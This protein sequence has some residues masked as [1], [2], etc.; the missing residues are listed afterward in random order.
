MEYS[1]VSKYLEELDELVHEHPSLPILASIHKV[2]LAQPASTQILAYNNNSCNFT[3]PCL[4]LL[5]YAKKHP[6]MASAEFYHVILCVGTREDE[7]FKSWVVRE[8][9]KLVRDPN[10]NRESVQTFRI[11]IESEQTLQKFIQKLKQQLSKES[12]QKLHDMILL[13]LGHRV[14]EEHV[15]KKR[16]INVEIALYLA[17]LIAFAQ[18]RLVA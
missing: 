3:V 13:E 16:K 12:M 1:S 14:V 7:D 10:L 5:R 17:L 11:A 15:Q 6:E 2:K 9:L 4:Y 18:D 8:K